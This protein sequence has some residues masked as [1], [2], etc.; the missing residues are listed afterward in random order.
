MPVVDTAPSAL[1]SK[2]KRMLHI[3]MPVRI[4][5]Q[6]N[7][8]V[9]SDFE[10]R[11]LQRAERRVRRFAMHQRSDEAT[12]TRENICLYQA[13]TVIVTERYSARSRRGAPFAQA[14]GEMTCR[15][16]HYIAA[17][18]IEESACAP[19]R[20]VRYGERFNMGCASRGASDPRCSGSPPQAGS[21]KIVRKIQRCYACPNMQSG[22]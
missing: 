17:P 3:R 15:A 12:T 16:L 2:Q 19:V 13:E 14:H 8:L 1:R 7:E 22:A 11:R 10:D 4:L 5:A 9:G 20:V 6:T 21:S 18:T